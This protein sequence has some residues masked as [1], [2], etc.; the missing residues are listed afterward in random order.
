MRSVSPPSHLPLP[1]FSLISL[2]AA[3]GG[4]VCI[5]CGMNAVLTS[6]IP[7]SP[8]CY[9]RLHQGKPYSVGTNCH[10]DDLLYLPC[11]QCILAGS[12]LHRGQWEWPWCARRRWVVTGA[13]AELLRVPTALHAQTQPQSLFPRSPASRQAPEK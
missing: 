6:I 4:L 2:L 7:T 8:R 5:S 10:S 12:L 11:S 1:S 13:A 3:T 9:L